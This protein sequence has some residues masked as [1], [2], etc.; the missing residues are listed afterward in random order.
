MRFRTNDL[1][2]A[3]V[4]LAI[5]I[6]LPMVIHISG[7]N[8]AVFLP[9]H[10]P[11]LVSGL[12][13]GSSLGLIVGIISPILNHTLTGMPPI[14]TLWIMLVELA[15]YGLISGYLYR[16]IKM[17][18]LPALISSMVLGRIAAALTVLVLGSAFSLPMPPLDI[19]IKGITITA[20]P[21]I[22]IQI[23]LIPP[24]VKA[25]ERNR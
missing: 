15:V 13:L 7:I 9:M 8:G 12:I 24:I 11:V 22:I 2:T 17:A 18:L 14:P 4:L 10:I 1:V 3:A 6:I 20:L 25:Y 21:G 19:Y 5:G 23:L 16:R